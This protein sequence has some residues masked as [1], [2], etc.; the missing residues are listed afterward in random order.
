MRQ[1]SKVSKGIK[2]NGGRSCRGRKEKRSDYSPL[3]M[4]QERGMGIHPSFLGMDWGGK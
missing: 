1:S 3:P 4:Y 2:K